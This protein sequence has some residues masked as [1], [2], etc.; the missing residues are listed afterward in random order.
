MRGRGTTDSGAHQKKTKDNAPDE[1]PSSDFEGDR[2]AGLG[3]W[4]VVED[5]VGP[6][7][8]GQH[9]NGRKD[10]ENVDK[11]VLEYDDVEPQIPEEKGNCEG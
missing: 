2:H 6:L 8:G 10:I 11:K 9:S 3:L 1:Q 7:L 4:T 5:L